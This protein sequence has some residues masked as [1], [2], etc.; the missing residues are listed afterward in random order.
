MNNNDTSVIRTLVYLNVL[1]WSRR[2][3][4]IEVGLYVD[5]LI[6]LANNAYPELDVKPQMRLALNQFTVEPC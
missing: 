6:S 5:T 4:I 3:R 1:A 2:V